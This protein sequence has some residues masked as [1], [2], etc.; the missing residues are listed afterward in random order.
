MDLGLSGRIYV[1]T[2]GTSGLGRAVAT[3]LVGEGAKVVVAS[4]DPDRVRAAVDGL[5]P[6]AHGVVADLTDPA[7]PASLVAAANERFGNL[8]GLFVSHGGPP[9][10]GALDLDDD[11]LAAAVAGSVMGPIRVVRDV[12][13]VLGP[14]ASIVVLTSTSSVQPIDGLVSS[15]V[16]RPAVWGYVKSLARELGPRGI[17]VNALLPG[18][19]ATDR[20]AQLDAANAQRD[21]I[22]P[23]EARDR[24][25]A[26]IPLRR[27][28]DPA[29]LG[30][31]AAFLLSPAASYV[32]GA[33]WTVDGGV[34]AGL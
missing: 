21:G 1:V 11:R 6:S 2:G 28:G 12:A 10:S 14:G 27:L 31:V 5:G 13:A 22:T 30:R 29:E 9:A 8:D 23:Q 15:N 32:T 19:F 26:A 3:E 34:I 7:S 4:R 16:A 18:R 17:R 24:S 25:V 33:A 20:V